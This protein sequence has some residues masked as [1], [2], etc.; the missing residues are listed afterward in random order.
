MIITLSPYRALHS[1]FRLALSCQGDVLTV[2]SSP[3]DFSPLPEGAVLPRDA[4]ALTIL[5]S[6]VTRT[7]G[8]VC[9]TLM[10]PIGPHAP[11]EAR[12]PAPIVVTSDGPVALPPD[13]LE[14]PATAEED[15][16]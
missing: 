1:V 16:A 11:L 5:E 14:P 13:D 3:F 15:D 8:H 2:G 10:F 7:G 12:F 6:D 4:V 9:L